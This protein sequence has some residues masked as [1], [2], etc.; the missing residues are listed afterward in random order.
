MGKWLAGILATVIAALAIYYLQ[1]LIREPQSPEPTKVVGYIVA[2]RISS[3]S[4]VT[5]NHTIC[6]TQSSIETARATPAISH[7]KLDILSA[8]E[9]YTAWETGVCDTVFFTDQ[10]QA[11]QVFAFKPTKTRLI[12]VMG[13]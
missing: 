5:S 8:P 10:S 12:K 6:G 1:P 3:T 9:L 2:G 4:D 13:F 11:D 7:A